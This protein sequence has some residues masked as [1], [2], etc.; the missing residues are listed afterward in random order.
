MRSLD[1]ARSAPFLPDTDAVR[2]ARGLR[3]PQ[4]VALIAFALCVGHA[5]YVVAA[6][7]LG[8][9]LYDPNGYS[10][11]DFVNVWAAGQLA[12]DG[13]PASAYDLALHKQAQVAALG[14]DFAGNY[15]WYYPPTYLF[16]AVL[17]ASFPY[18][19][20]WV[21]WACV[22]FPAYLAATRAIIADRVAFLLAGAFPAILSNFLVGQNGF[23]T[24]GLL[25]GALV[26]MQ[27]RPWLSGCL[28]GLLSY[29]PHLGLLFP[30]VLAIGGEWR[31]FAA[32]ATTV[33]GLIAGSWL[34]FG[35][36]AWEAFFRSLSSGSQSILSHGT[37]AWGNLQSMY[38]LI[39]WLGASEALAWSVHGLLAS[40]CALAICLLWRSRA[41]FAIK[42]A[43]LATGALLST[44]YLF[45]YDLVAL[46][47]PMAFLLRAGAT[48]EIAIFE[49]MALGLASLSILLY[50]AFEAPVGV[51]AMLIVAGLVARRAIE[52]TIARNIPAPSAI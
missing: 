36:G 42:A 31:V 35:D 21:G 28:L 17:L 2:P 20:A 7:W 52:A 4:P 34:T 41:P 5:V 23:L 51:P 12:L 49:W 14:H 47:I 43:A 40:A 50:P 24:A 16:V 27:R 44:P 37:V 1:A 10:G 22:T 25:G 39:R 11:S 46:A 8:Y 38:G 32:A 9:W 48:A 33:A 13:A 26:T 30:V 18:V 19:L 3:L 45:L 15:P 29:K 6:Y